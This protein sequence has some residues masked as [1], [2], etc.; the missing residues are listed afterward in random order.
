[1]GSLAATTP[2]TIAIVGCSYVGMRLAQALVPVLPPA[3]RVVVVEANSHFHHLFTFPRFSVLHRGGEE[4]ALIPYSHALEAGSAGNAIIHAKALSIH[5]SPSNASKGYLK[6]DRAAN[7]GSDTL[8]FDY[9][10]IATG[11][12]LQEPWSLPPTSNDGVE[13]KKQAVAT[14]RSYQDAVK[15]AKHIVVIGGGAVGVQVAC[16]ISELYPLGPNK[17]VTVL[18]SRERVMNKFHPNLHSLV[19]ER[20]A[21]HNIS[22]HL[23]SRVVIPSGGF[24][25]FKEGQV[26]DVELQ[27]GQKVKADLVLMCTGQTPRSS[28]LSSFAPEAITTDGFIDVLPTLQIKASPAGL[29]GRIFALGDIANSGAAKT[30]RAAVGQIDVIKSNILS[31]IV[32]EQKGANGKVELENFTPAPSGIHLS[33]RLYESVK[34][35]NPA[36]EGGEPWC[37]GLER[38]L[39]LD[40]GIE[41][42]WRKWGV[43]QGTPWHL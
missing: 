5:T 23:G 39:K 6:L 35:G 9:L 22:T 21:S 7:K 16:D 43:P 1:M 26:F 11:T 19:A 13:A 20:F 12:Q 32:A 42:T 14:L 10:A 34:F 36:Q 38:D 27:N 25:A 41:E 3:H 29:G 8:E 17:T 30:V 37:K 2:S 28:L 40:M 31:L 15:Q 4:K 18:H 24:P 33:L